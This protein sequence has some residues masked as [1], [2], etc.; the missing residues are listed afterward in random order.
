[1]EKRNCTIC[2]RPTEDSLL[3]VE[4]QENVCW[5]CGAKM[6]AKAK[7]EKR[8]IEIT[9]ESG[10]TC[11]LCNWCG[12]LFPESILR[13]ETDLGHLCDQCVSAIR[14]RGESLTLK[15]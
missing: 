11:R 4:D 14:S 15:Y 6:A 5:D 8:E 13:E 12:D 1:M 3:T 2:G 7:A 10:D 9:D